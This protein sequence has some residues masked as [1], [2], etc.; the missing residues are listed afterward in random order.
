MLYSFRFL[1]KFSSSRLNA[2]GYSANNRW[3]Q[4]LAQPIEPT[5]E[6]MTVLADF[7]SQ[8]PITKDEL[9]GFMA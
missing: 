5:E 6:T 4:G 3:A 7:V 8:N 9:E 2:R 1:I